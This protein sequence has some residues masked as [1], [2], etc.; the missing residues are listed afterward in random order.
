MINEELP[1]WA[2]QFA[3]GESAICKKCGKVQDVS[4]SACISCCK[5]DELYFTEE[6]HCGWHLDVECAICG[7][8][9]G[10]DN[11]VIIREYKVVRRNA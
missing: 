8:N 10:F 1:G 11:D 4:F 5:H 2:S 6:W 3:D 7:K 9:F